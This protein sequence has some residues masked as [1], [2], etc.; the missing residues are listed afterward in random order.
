[1]VRRFTSE[2]LSLR[3][4]LVRVEYSSPPS[5]AQPRPLAWQ[6]PA[7]PR[8]DLT[9]PAGGLTSEKRNKLAC[10]RRFAFPFRKGPSVPSD[11]RPTPRPPSAPR[12]GAGSEEGNSTQPR[13]HGARI[14][15]PEPCELLGLRNRGAAPSWEANRPGQLS[16]RPRS[17]IS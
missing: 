1:M 12:A 5:Q 8:G 16:S 9:S 10:A 11:L 17:S 4:M 7:T 3:E 6:E 14:P 13:G 15:R 2:D